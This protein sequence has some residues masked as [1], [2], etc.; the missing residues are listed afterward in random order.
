MNVEGPMI[1]P[2]FCYYRYLRL[3]LLGCALIKCVVL[4]NLQD[5]RV[6]EGRKGKVDEN[7]WAKAWAWDRQSMCTAHL[8]CDDLVGWDMPALE[9]LE[10]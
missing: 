6:D 2:S 5:K 4:G 3:D 10:R 9:H 7:A 8:D 1:H